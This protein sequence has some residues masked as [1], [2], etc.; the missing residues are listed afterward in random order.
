MTPIEVVMQFIDRIN[1][2]DL[3]GLCALLASDHCFTDSLG[4]EVRGRSAM[5]AAWRQY[6]VMVPDYRIVPTRYFVDA[7]TVAIFGTAEGSCTADGTSQSSNFW[8]TP[9][10]WRAVVDGMMVA[11]WQVYADNEPIRQIMAR[12]AVM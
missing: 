10:A 3:P 6:F 1:A 9:A 4:E 5:C 12:E 2:H 7:S 8:R 11:E